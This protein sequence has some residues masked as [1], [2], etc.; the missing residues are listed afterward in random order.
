MREGEK[1]WV[2][3][4]PADPWQEGIVVDAERLHVRLENSGPDAFPTAWK[5]I[6]READDGED[7]LERLGG[8]RLGSAATATDLRA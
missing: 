5:Y 2:R 4:H 3:S 7:E 6:C 1:V 8:A